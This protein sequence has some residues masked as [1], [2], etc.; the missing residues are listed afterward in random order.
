MLM[1]PFSF[2]NFFLYPAPLSGPLVTADAL[3]GGKSTKSVKVKDNLKKD[4]YLFKRRED[5]IT[6]QVVYREETPDAAGCYVF[7]KRTPVLESSAEAGFISHDIAAST[8]DAKEAVI[9]QVQADGSSLTPQVFSSD[10]KP[11]LD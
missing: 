1:L 9:G 5:P 4:K 8:S 2:F 10:A 3:G 11:H 7:Q 6:S